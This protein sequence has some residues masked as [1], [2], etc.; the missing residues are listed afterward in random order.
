VDVLIPPGETRSFLWLVDVFPDCVPLTGRVKLLAIDED[1]TP[2]ECYADVHVPAVG[3]FFSCGLDA[4]A[5][6]LEYNGSEKRYEPTEVEFEGWIVNRMSC[7]AEQVTVHFGWNRPFGSIEFFEFDPAYPSDDTLLIFHDVIPGD[8]LRGRWKVRLTR[9][10]TFNSDLDVGFDLIWETDEA[11]SIF[12]RSSGA[13]VRVQMS[14]IT[15][16]TS[17]GSPL[18]FQF[19]S[20]YPNPFTTETAVTFS[21]SRDLSVRLEV[22]DILGRR[23][24]LLHD[25][26]LQAGEHIMRFDATGLPDGMYLIRLSGGEEHAETRA[27]K[28]SR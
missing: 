18:T 12:Q 24:A 23:V 7:A 6:L 5:Y 13:S 19:S 20:G 14:G 3:I 17:V 8:T 11:W 1:G 25:G 2:W 22:F 15:S 10:N 27:L 28:I 26:R 4:S 21:L 9:D 16:V